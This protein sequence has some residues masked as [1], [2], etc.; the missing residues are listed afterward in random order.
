[1]SYVNGPLR[2]FFAYEQ[3]NASNKLPSAQSSA[4]PR[5][6]TVGGLYDFDVL[7]LVIAYERATDG[8]FAGKSLPSGATF[9]SVRGTP[10]NAFIDGFSANSYLLAIAVP[11]GGASSM[12]GSW[13]RVDPNN[14]NLTGGDSM[15]NT[16]G[17]GYSYSLSK[18]TSLYAAASYTKNF[19]FLDS[20][21]VT[22]AMIGLRHAF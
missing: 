1:M 12:F 4:T 16:F 7:K 21:K 9:G 10:N 6:F 13:Q 17:L 20:A 5:S 22:E 2:A 18:R 8:W 11:L 14:S 15:T 19:A 3:L